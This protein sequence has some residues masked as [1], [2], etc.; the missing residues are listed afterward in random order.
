MMRAQAAT[1]TNVRWRRETSLLSAICLLV[2]YVLAACSSAPPPKPD[3]PASVSPGWKLSSF[4]KAAPPPEIP[5]HGA[6]S[7]W[8]AAYAAE[9]IADVWICG[10]KARA[11]AFDATQRVRAE[12]Q[13]V[14]FQE[15]RYFVLVK[16]NNVPKARITVLVR[17]LEKALQPAR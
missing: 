8:K 13:A 9:G 3:I 2:F 12:A 17:A 15:D 7:C 16:W 14:K 10:Y 1:L 6:P 5:A 11:N 4:D